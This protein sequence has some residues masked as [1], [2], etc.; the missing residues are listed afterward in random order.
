VDIRQA[1]A[2]AGRLV[3]HAP[4]GGDREYGRIT[5]ASDTTVFVC[6]QGETS[7]RGTDPAHLELVTLD[8]R[9]GPADVAAAWLPPGC[10]ASLRGIPLASPGLELGWWVT[11]NGTALDDPG[12]VRW[13]ATPESARKAHQAHGQAMWEA[14][15]RLLWQAA[16]ASPGPKALYVQ[17]AEAAA[18]VPA[19]QPCTPVPGWRAARIR[20]DPS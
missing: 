4:A 13:F 1:Q 7:A 16:R 19:G 20:R 17:H 3:A 14:A 18:G 2:S 15:A 12:R 6:Y 11:V 10:G 5:Q 8:L 9:P